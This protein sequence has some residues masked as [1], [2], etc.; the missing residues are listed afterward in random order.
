MASCLRW[1]AFTDRTSPHSESSSFKL[2]TRPGGGALMSD[3]GEQRGGGDTFDHAT[4]TSLHQKVKGEPPYFFEFEHGD[5]ALQERVGLKTGRFVFSP[6]PPSPSSTFLSLFSLS[7]IS[8]PL[9]IC[10]L[11]HSTFSL[12]PPHPSLTRMLSH[13]TERTRGIKLGRTYR[14]R[15][16]W[17]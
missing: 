9:S 1:S 7:S 5:H 12:L 4:N 2:T 10:C 15:W 3:T 11:S 13:P 16:R 6:S 8:P 17:Q 14:Q